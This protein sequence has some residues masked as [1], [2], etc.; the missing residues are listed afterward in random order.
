MPD[1]NAF[2]ACYDMGVHWAM[3]HREV[4][5]KLLNKPAKF[6]DQARLAFEISGF[7]ECAASLKSRQ[8]Y[9]YRRN[10]Q[11]AE[12]KFVAGA[13]NSMNGDLGLTESSGTRK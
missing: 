4:L 5:L 3:R 10:Q 11:V 2:Q 7:P 1:E 9:Y 13:W 6:E 12:S 8:Y